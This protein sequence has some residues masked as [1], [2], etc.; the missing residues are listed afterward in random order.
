MLLHETLDDLHK[1]K[2]SWLLFKIDFEKAFDKIKWP[3]LLQMLE[4]KGF[5]NKWNDLI[6]K[7]FRVG[8]WQLRSMERWEHTS[9]LIKG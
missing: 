5:P 6:L 8:K 2:S 9:Q 3:F 4:M 1:K 7:L